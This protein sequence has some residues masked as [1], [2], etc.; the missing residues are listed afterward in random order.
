MRAFI[1]VT[2][3]VS[4]PAAVAALSMLLFTACTSGNMAR[5]VADAR[6]AAATDAEAIAQLDP[7][8]ASRMQDTRVLIRRASMQLVD[9]E[10][11]RVAAERVAAIARAMGGFVERSS[12]STRGGVHITIRIPSASLDAAMDSV[13]RLGRVGRRDIR[14]DDV[15]ERVVDLDARVAAL[16][17]TRDRLRQLLER[18]TTVADV[19]TVER[20]LARVQG[21][22]DSLEGRL[23][24][25]RSAAAMAELSVEADRKIVLGPLGWIAVKTGAL[26]EKL[27]VWRR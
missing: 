27:F 6:P 16:R 20:E 26:I 18:A 14:E 23:K 19:V 4:A 5:S 25:V 1:S 7:A 3:S 22:L 24:H 17:A 12:E 13:S 21:E 11:P 9:L 2:R 10:D 15:T 8:E